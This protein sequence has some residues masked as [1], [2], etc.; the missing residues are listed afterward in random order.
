MVGS[1]GEKIGEGAVSDVHSWAPGQVVKL[2][3]AGVP[4]RLAVHEARMTRAVFAAGAPAP[5]AFDE[6]TVDGRHGIVLTRFDGPTLQHLSRTGAMTFEQTGAVLAAL[7]LAVSGTPPPTDLPPLRD[8]LEGSFRLAG[9]T[10]P[11]ALAPGVMSLIDRLE[12]ADG[13]CHGDLHSGNVIMT[14]EGPRIIDWT[15]VVRAPAALDLACCHI[16]MAEIA[17]AIVPDSERPIAVNAALQAAYARLTG[18]SLAALT[19]EVECYLPIARV[20]YLLGGAAPNLREGMIAKVMAA[21][22]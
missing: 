15:G 19:A 17:P 8:Y 22:A 5:Q 12:P 4:R 11:E 3:R 10:L 13:L 16:A 2:F 18:V 7:C 20:L 9:R 1:L 6:V 21:L 14:P